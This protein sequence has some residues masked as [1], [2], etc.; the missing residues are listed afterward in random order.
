M[1]TIKGAEKAL[2][3]SPRAQEAGKHHTGTRGLLRTATEH[4][5]HFRSHRKC[6]KCR[7]THVKGPWD[8]M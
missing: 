7:Y 1:R 4:G 5:R 2:M 6:H 8:M 3:R